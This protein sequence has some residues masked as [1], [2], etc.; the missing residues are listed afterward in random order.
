MTLTGPDG[1]TSARA[2][3]TSPRGTLYNSG[4]PETPDRQYWPKAYQDPDRD[5]DK[6]TLEA[7]RS[8]SRRLK[9]NCGVVAG[10]IKR[11][12]EY[13]A[14]NAWKPS[15]R[16]P[17]GKDW[18]N[19]AE[20]YLRDWYDKCDIAGRSVNFVV[21][22]GLASEA[23][24]V[25]GDCAV[26][27]TSDPESGAARI[28]WLAAHRIGERRIASPPLKEGWTSDEYGR[29]FDAKGRHRQWVVR[30]PDVDGMDYGASDK[31]IDVSSITLAYEPEWFGAAR[32]VPKLASAINHLRDLQDFEK[33]ELLAA[34][35]SAAITVVESNE[36]GGPDFGI[37]NR[38]PGDE[39]KLPIYQEMV[40]GLYRYF[41]AGSGGKIDS[42]QHDRPTASLYSAADYL[43]R[44]AFSALGWPSEL[45][46]NSSD[47]GGAN[48]RM[49]ISMAMRTVK[50]RQATLR[51]LAREITLYGLGAGIA[52]D[53][54]PWADGWWKGWDWSMPPTLSVDAGRDRAAEL[55]DYRAGIVNLTDILADSGEDIE[56][57]FNTRAH[58]EK[59][60]KRIAEESG[61]PIDAFGIVA[62]PGQGAPTP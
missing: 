18:G 38:D 49:V 35:A 50:S 37:R 22:L 21:G 47:I 9:A 44:T 48:T 26:M 40:G 14:G 36:E 4:R 20:A 8:H 39:K 12:A 46:W 29:I 28:Q 34:K 51:L 1:K 13:S 23:I 60:R 6:L 54:I 58:E 27:K 32:G 52:R 59:L 55:N 2:W 61:L 42:F 33:F 16:G 11:K 30:A 3:V 43:Y 15:Y 57:H 25:D 10:A 56:D 53:E 41:R 24:D 7:L 31:Y 45:A 17:A 62:M 19:V 5:L